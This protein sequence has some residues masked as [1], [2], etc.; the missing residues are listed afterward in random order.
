MELVSGNISRI[1]SSGGVQPFMK[2]GRYVGRFS[3]HSSLNG[4][5][6]LQI[7]DNRAKYDD[8]IIHPFEFN[9]S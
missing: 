9:H 1:Q 8:Q 4:L 5:N 6:Y 3:C 2:T 7:K